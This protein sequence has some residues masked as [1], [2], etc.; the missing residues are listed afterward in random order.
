MKRITS[1]VTAL[2]LTLLGLSSCDNTLNVN[3][4]WVETPVLYGILDPK[5]DTHYVRIGRAYLGQE[6]AEGGMQSPD[7][8]YYP[9]LT[10]VLEELNATTGAVKA[11]HSL[12]EA[13]YVT[14]NP[15]D[16]TPLGYKVYQWIGSLNENSLY[17]VKAFKPGVTTALVSATTPLIYSSKFILREPS[18]IG[19]ANIRMALASRSGQ[20][21]RWDQPKNGRLYQGFMRFHYM[22]MPV[23][24]QSDSTLH[25]VDYPLSTITGSTMNGGTDI[26]TT[27]GFTDFYPWLA[28]T[29]PSA[30]GK[31]RWFRTIDLYINVASDDLATYI[32]VTQPSNTIVQDK[33]FFTNVSGGAGIFGSRSH[34]WRKNL[35]ISANSLDSL[36]FSRKTCT[37]RF[38][39]ASVLDTLTC[40]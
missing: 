1:A 21:V 30:E 17:R 20:K 31:L 9:N 12:S 16:F 8:L 29:L 19:G 2:V 11:T 22:E 35:N 5:Q 39:K 34:F 37:L 7:S 27:I 10:V 23:G 40:N 18:P 6:G 4:P 33:P 13:T 15:G 24:K 26:G 14:L 3:A 36:V 32:S 38:A 25:F 28:A